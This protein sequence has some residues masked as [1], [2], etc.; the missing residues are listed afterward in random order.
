MLFRSH[1][2][3]KGVAHPDG[4]VDV[5]A[6]VGGEVFCAGTTRVIGRGSE[7]GMI[8]L[9]AGD[10]GIFALIPKSCRTGSGEKM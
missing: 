7:V 10:D 9:G 4:L 2:N 5:G 8:I 6:P 1:G 3:V